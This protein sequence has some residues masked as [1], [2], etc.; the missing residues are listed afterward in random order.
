MNTSE[1]L[2]G[3]PL[4]LEGKAAL[5]E[6]AL[7]SANVSVLF[8]DTTLAIRYADNLPEHLMPSLLIGGNDYHLFGDKDG[9]HLTLL[10]RGVLE[11][12]RAV[13]AEVEIAS[14][15]GVRI[16]ELK[17]ERVGGRKAQGV[18]SVISEVTESRHREKVL[19]SLL[20]ELSH[21]SKNLLAIIQGIATQTAR[22]TLSL[23]NFLIKF[24]GRLQSLSNSQDLITD[25]SWR[26]AY[27]FELA[28]KQFAPYWPD[29]GVPM[30]IYG[31]NAH[32]TPNAAVHLGLALHELIVN[33]ASHGAISAGAT[34]ITLNCKEAEL[35]GKKAIEVAWLERFH[36]PA[37]HEFEDNSFSRT[38][39]ER[40]VPTSMNGRAQFTISD[41]NIGYH[42]TIPETEYEILRRR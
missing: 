28:E 24:R 21:R 12:G 18:L 10:K 13:T 1:P 22:H 17:M 26:G 19:K 33:S 14:G 35:D 31:I 39:L 7:A 30:P 2:S 37:D 4:S 41:G 20:R 36:A 6:R 32:L 29:A 5:M 40:V 11:N 42:L 16:Y 3:A 34:S 23:D 25:S 27:L 15:D 38:V 9:E 8:Q